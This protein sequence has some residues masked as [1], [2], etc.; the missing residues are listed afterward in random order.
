M[1]NVP[2]YREKTDFPL[3]CKSQGHKYPNN[4]LLKGGLRHETRHTSKRKLSLSLSP[5][6]S[7][8]II[9]LLNTYL[10]V[11]GV[12]LGKNTRGRPSCRTRRR[13]VILARSTVPQPSVSP[14]FRPI[15][16]SFFPKQIGAV[17]GEAQQNG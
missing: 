4:Y 5:S 13:R 11:G 3:G 2:P 16:S 17:C 12:F 1:V 9:S 7:F 10:T 8:Y 15:S 14:S 6:L